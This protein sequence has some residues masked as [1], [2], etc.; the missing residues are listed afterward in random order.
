MVTEPVAV[1]PIFI[2]VELK[3][4][5][6]P[7]RLIVSEPEAKALD[8]IVVGVAVKLAKVPPTAATVTTETAARLRRIF[9]SG[10]FLSIVRAGPFTGLTRTASA[11]PE[12]GRG[13]LEDES[14]KSE[15]RL[16]RRFSRLRAA[17]NCWGQTPIRGSDPVVTRPCATSRSAGV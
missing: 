10:S 7:E 4:A 16:N 14:G 8:A 17:S 11:R 9:E 3:M 13:L 1:S 12:W 15:D 2:A 5:P 6:E